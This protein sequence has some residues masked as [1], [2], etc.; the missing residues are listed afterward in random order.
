MGAQQ[1]IELG[2]VGE[3]GWFSF[4][5]SGKKRCQVIKIAN[6]KGGQMVFW[7]NNQTGE[8]GK[9]EFYKEVWI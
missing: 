1:K 4:R 5:E 3:G 8:M 9:S 7:R 2:F 6:D